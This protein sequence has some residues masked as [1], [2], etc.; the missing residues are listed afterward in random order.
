M[1]RIVPY[2]VIDMP[3]TGT[4]IKL[5]IAKSGLT[6]QEVRAY[7]SFEEPTAI[8]NW[9]RGIALPTVD[10]LLALSKLLDVPMEE[11]LVVR[12]PEHTDQHRPI[13]CRNVIDFFNL[14][15]VA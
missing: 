5:L 11:I 15:L 13:K 12:K 6:V 2:P 8:Y 14:L 10:H 1:R 7:F 9:Q 3:K 4:N